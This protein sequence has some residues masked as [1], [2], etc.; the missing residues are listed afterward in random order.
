MKKS[1]FFLLII[2][3]VS[4]NKKQPASPAVAKRTIVECQLYYDYDLETQEF[5]AAPLTMPVIRKNVAATLI[6]G[7]LSAS[8]KIKFNNA[9]QAMKNITI[10]TGTLTATHRTGWNFQAAIHGTTMMV[11]PNGD[12]IPA[13]WKTCQHGS[14]FFLSWHRM[15]LYFFERILRS[16]MSGSISTKPGLPYWDI[17]TYNKIPPIFRSTYPALIDTRNTGLNTGAS[18]VST[19][20]FTGNAINTE[21]NTALGET[22]FYLFQQSLETP[23]GGVHGAIGHNMGSFNTA[24]KDPIFWVHH[25]NFDR[26]WEEWLNNGG[27]RCNPDIESD[28]TWWNT[29]FTFYDEK[30]KPKTMTAADIVRIAPDLG[31]RYQK[32]SSL[33]PLPAD[34]PV[35]PDECDRSIK[36]CEA[37]E[38]TKPKLKITYSNGVINQ[39][40]TKFNFSARAS[41]QLDSILT[42]DKQFEF[43]IF[44]T[45]KNSV[46]F[47]E[48]EN[49]VI[50]KAPEGIVEVYINPKNTP[51]LL[52]E[53]PSFAGVLDFFTAQA[54]QGHHGS[55]ILRL[56]ITSALKGLKFDIMSFRKMEIVFVIRGNYLNDKEILTDGD[57]RIGKTTVA[58]YQFE[59][60]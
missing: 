57:I 33:I 44:G 26:L 3:T 27:G 12:P 19:N 60:K 36:T 46:F 5:V 32:G 14:C 53:N 59:D 25:A 38:A 21:I 52:P 47:L 55:K 22:N 24:A 7:G 9:V 42:G 35:K 11:M 17:Q 23:H 40:I 56:N 4:F 29:K 58:F 51:P 20:P 45:G 15:Y 41:A 6:A 50:N 1:F 48:F 31:Y 28:P 34:L 39:R 54:M 2:A 49:L 18:I 8:E 37:Y 43:S 16:K 13:G 10:P 30:G